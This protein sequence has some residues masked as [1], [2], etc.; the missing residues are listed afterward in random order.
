M[1]NLCEV[2]I[3]DFKVKQKIR[4]GN[5]LSFEI[6]LSESLLEIEKKLFSVYINFY[7]H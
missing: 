6:Y 3:L 4:V 1:L 7:V 5:Q 2:E